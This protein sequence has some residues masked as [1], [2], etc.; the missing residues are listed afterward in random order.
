MHF[1]KKIRNFTNI[2]R[3]LNHY[4]CNLLI[5]IKMWIHILDKLNFET[6]V[7]LR[8]RWGKYY[9]HGKVAAFCIL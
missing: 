5:L 2:M 7:K 1:F 4:Q 6:F 9:L 3:G 8:F